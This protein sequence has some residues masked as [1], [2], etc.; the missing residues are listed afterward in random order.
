[1]G[2][3]TGSSHIAGDTV[4]LLLMAYGSDAICA[5]WEAS[6]VPVVGSD[7]KSIPLVFHMP[8]EDATIVARGRHCFPLE[9]T[10]NSGAW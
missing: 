6:L 8:A 5:G 4:V 3:T 7:N 10:S 9:V 2:C 1:V